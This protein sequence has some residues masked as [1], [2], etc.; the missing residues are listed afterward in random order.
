LDERGIS[1]E[2]VEVEK[3]GV[4]AGYVGRGRGETGFRV[5]EE[6]SEEMGE[7]G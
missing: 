3:A 2:I 1:G 7:H 6:G 5:G 4:S